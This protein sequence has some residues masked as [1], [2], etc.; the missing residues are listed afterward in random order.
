[1]ELHVVEPVF[2]GLTKDGKMSTRSKAAQEAREAWLQKIPKDAIVLTQ[3]DADRIYSIWNTLKE[4]KL[5]SNILKDG[6]K[7]QSVWTKDPETGVHLACR[8]D[9]ISSRGHVIDI[10]TTRNASPDFFLSQVFSNRGYSQ[11]YILQSSHY[12]HVLKTAGISDGKSF[13]FIAMASAPPYE[14]RVYPLDEGALDAGDSWR[15]KLT[16]LYADCLETDTWPGYDDTAH[17]TTLPSWF[18]DPPM[19]MEEEP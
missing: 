2:Q 6:V 9:F 8:P 4:K 10:K 1:M 11:F 18:N 19:V 5:I 17:P 13:L 3:T 15:K 7:E 12:T 14:M 16:R